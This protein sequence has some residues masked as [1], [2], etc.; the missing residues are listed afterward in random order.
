MA[1]DS[2]IERKRAEKFYLVCVFDLFV[3]LI[4]AVVLAIKLIWL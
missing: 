3:F 2:V 1:Y 4:T